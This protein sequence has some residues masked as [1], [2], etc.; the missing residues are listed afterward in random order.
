MKKITVVGRGTVG[1]LSVMHFLRHTNYAVDWVY[2]PEIEPAAVGEGTTLTVP[3]ALWDNARI[4]NDDLQR[5]NTTPKIGIMKRNWG[6]AGQQYLH[7]FPA[8]RVGIHFNAVEFQKWMFERFS[9]NRR[10]T[11]I[12][13]TVDYSGDIDSDY[14]MYC[15]G[16]PKLGT[17]HEIITSIPVNACVVNQCPWPLAKFNYTLTYA[18]RYG[19][20]FGIPL[21]NRC[22]IG[23]LYN[24]DLN[25]PEDLVPEINE[26]LA[27]LGLTPNVTRQLKFNNYIRKVNYTD[28]VA[29]NGNASFFLEPLEATSTAFA[30]MINRQTFDIWVNKG[31]V[32]KYNQ[33]YQTKAHEI[34]NMISLHYFA[35]S[36]YKTD[37]WKMANQKCTRRITDQISNNK[38]FRR[39]LKMVFNRTSLFEDISDDIG[40]WGLYG[41]G[42]N[43]E[44]LGITEQLKQLLEKDD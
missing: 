43:I 44:N 11:T 16:S 24:S 28:R 33:L 10:I 35:G 13:R 21:Q 19:W 8:G 12:E 15:T 23:Y 37:F 2:D 1:C 14:V 29:Y 38:E 17:E 6:S 26:L 18:M 25:T 32:E 39:L 3:T 40:T 20:V 4:S 42:L 27:E 7:P 31:S 22:A 34:E 41:Y 30:D 9:A 5:V 36:V